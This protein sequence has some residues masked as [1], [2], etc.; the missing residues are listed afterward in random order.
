MIRDDGT[1]P[2]PIENRLAHG[3]FVAPFGLAAVSAMAI[4]HCSFV[5]DV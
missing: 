2:G 4:S 3:M 1:P 5:N